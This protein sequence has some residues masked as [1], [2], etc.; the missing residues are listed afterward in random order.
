MDA[1]LEF[2]LPGPVI[3]TVVEPSF[4]APDGTDAETVGSFAPAL[5]AVTRALIG[6]P[7]PSSR[8]PHVPSVT[9]SQTWSTAGEPGFTNASTTWE[10]GLTPNADWTSNR[11]AALPVISGSVPALAIVPWMSPFAD[12]NLSSR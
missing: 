3:V 8:V 2:D 9:S 11:T 5:Y 1:F 6:T 7:E 12:T 10:A 4:A